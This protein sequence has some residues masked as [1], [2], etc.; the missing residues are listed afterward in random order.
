MRELRRTTAL[1]VLLLGLMTITVY[2]ESSIS[3]LARDDDKN[4]K[5]DKN[6]NIRDHSQKG[7]DLVH[8]QAVTLKNNFLQ[9]SP[10]RPNTNGPIHSA[11]TTSLL[12]KDQPQLQHQKS[13]SPKRPAAGNQQKSQS[14]VRPSDSHP[15][16]G[17]S[18]QAHGGPNND[19]PEDLDAQQVVNDMVYWRDLPNDAKWQSPF[20]SHDKKK[21]KYLAF[22]SDEGGFNNIRMAFETALVL[23]IGTGRIL[24]LPP[25]MDFYLLNPGSRLRPGSKRP[26]GFSD[27]YDLQAIAHEHQAAAK[28]GAFQMI[29]F[30]EFLETEAM[31]GTL[32][33]HRTGRPTFPP[34][35]ITNWNGGLA[36]FMVFRTNEHLKGGNSLWNWMRRISYSPAW[37]PDE[38]V[39]AIPRVPGA[40][41]RDELEH[42][43]WQQ[44]VQVGD[45]IRRASLPPVLRVNA[46]M[47]WR[48]R[49]HSF[50]GNPTPV[51]ATAKDRLSE[52]LA[53]RKSICLY[54]ETLQN[55]QVLHLKGEQK[56]GQ[57]M[58][59]HFYAF[60]FFQDW[61][62]DLWMKRFVRDH[63]RYHDDIQCA[64]ARIVHAVRKQARI[65][66]RN[67]K[68]RQN[69]MSS[70]TL[71]EH[72]NG[73]D[74]SF[75]TIHIRRGD[76]QFKP[77]RHMTAESIYD[78]NVR[79]W[80]TP[81]KVL[82]VATD[83]K[84][85]TFFEPLRKHYHLV[86][87]NDFKHLLTG[88]DYH[89]YGMIDQLVAAMGDVFVGVFFSTFTGFINRLRGYHSQKRQ[90]PG[91][92]QGELPT[93][94][95]YAPNSLA[96]K[97]RSMH[98][99][100]AVEPAFWQREFPVAWRDLDHPPS[101]PLVTPTTT[102]T[103]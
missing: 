29:T 81:G 42:K 64:A 91:Y 23:A 22:E 100:Q 89:Y 78:D 26:F 44:G 86:F 14:F 50:D 69:Q 93:T 60:I 88:V 9:Q 84:N 36:N 90:L 83:E 45:A 5:N 2:V 101:P 48:N 57:R 18:C 15:V 94:Y 31:A 7:K 73:D 67:L 96:S 87:F 16:A 75:H 99:Y 12:S 3:S 19:D 25:E 49:F 70:T 61:R 46:N 52:V 27:F 30:E 41:A 95:Y 40:D 85:M 103:S 28:G 65:V 102:T 17:L 10:L 80:F 11:T 72:K 98:K 68:A 47:V 74:T 34:G 35:N 6:N 43:V 20:T 51:N 76:F 53:Q 77:L 32:L 56:S 37:A 13:V 54:N 62:Q 66:N 55:A 63:L 39:A 8:S 33:D 1:L 4:D 59:V 71:N 58:L 97:R 21:K 24:V 92:Q 82:Y 79:R 38:C